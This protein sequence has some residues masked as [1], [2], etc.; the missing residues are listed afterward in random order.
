MIS[1]RLVALVSAFCI[2]LGLLVIISLIAI[3][4]FQ[5]PGT[6]ICPSLYLEP[7]GSAGPRTNPGQHS[8]TLAPPRNVFLIQQ[9]CNH[10]SSIE[11]APIFLHVQ[12]DSDELEIGW[13]T[14]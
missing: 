4:E 6:G 5:I 1:S 10:K 9:A 3:P 11:G 14:P 13:A 7:A 8:P 2:T 12:T